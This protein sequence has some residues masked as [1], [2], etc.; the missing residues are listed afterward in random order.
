MRLV[1]FQ[2]QLF[3]TLKYRYRLQ[4]IVHIEQKPQKIKIMNEGFNEKPVN[5]KSLE[6]INMLL[7]YLGRPSV[8]VLSQR[9][10][11]KHNPP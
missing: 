7:Q 11:S 8:Q 9:V 1:V 4:L 3:K 6:N 2:P 10:T 5:M